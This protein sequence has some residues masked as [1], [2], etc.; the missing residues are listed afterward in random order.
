MPP[1]RSN[2][3][4]SLPTLGDNL[5]RVS[6]NSKSN[7]VLVLP[8]QYE[9]QWSNPIMTAL[10]PPPS[11]KPAQPQRKNSHH[12][13]RSDSGLALHTNQAAFRQRKNSNSAGPVST[14]H[15]PARALS[16]DSN[17]SVEEFAL[18]RSFSPELGGFVSNGRVIPDFFEP[19]VVKLAFSNKE[20]VRRLCAFAETRHDGSD[21]DFLRKVIAPH[22]PNVTT[23]DMLIRLQVE[24]Y[25]RA[26]G[27]LISSMSYISSNFTGTTATSPLELSSEVAGALKS[28]IKFCAR[29]ALPALDKVY[30]DAKSTAEDRLSKS[31]YPEFVKYQLSQ[32]LTTSLTSN[33]SLAGETNTPY[34]GLGEAFCLTDPHQPDNPVI[35]ASDGLSAML[36]YSRRQ[37]VGRNCRLLQ[38]IATEATAAFRLSQAVG[39]GREATELLINYRPDGTPYWNL[40]F[41]CPLMENGTVRYFL[42]AQVNVSENMGSD[43]M[44]IMGVLNFGPPR[45]EQ[46]TLS[47]ESPTSPIWPARQSSDKL[48][49]P[50]SNDQHEEKFEGK[51]GSR[52]WR[53]FHRLHRKA[54][55]LRASSPSHRSTASEPTTDDNS[56][57]P[58]ASRNCPPLSP[59]SAHMELHQR[60]PSEQQL[61]ENST[62]YSRFLVMRYTSP[63]PPSTSHNRRQQSGSKRLAREERS[64]SATPRLPVSFCSSHALS[65]LGLET[66]PQPHSRPPESPLLGSDIFSV[67][68]SHLNSPTLDRVFKA[69]MLARL[70][71][72]ESVRADLMVRVGGPE[73]SARGSRS[74]APIIQINGTTSGSATS[75]G[76]A[77]PFDSRPRVSSSLDRGSGLLSHVL[78]P[79]GRGAYEADC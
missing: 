26:L 78:S 57:P 3:A 38:G 56:S 70:D 23:P 4:D 39:A 51:P 12:R 67:L 62:P 36:G 79:G 60:R 59:F 72:G 29:S 46:P 40:L 25:S 18:G 47:P 65:L 71:R 69:E 34:P 17:S 7:P 41:I 77:L 43:Y 2:T 9:R 35:F 1:V 24:E 48:E 13:L 10:S 20:T 45:Q 75:S 30:R 61:D 74:G 21:I 76:E 32:R 49:V 5:N 63:H 15:L 68:S 58:Q 6:R 28:D 31:L 64:R 53:F 27:N 8:Q 44:E 11:S 55:S 19:A 50:N 52:R 73:G 54:P 42:G 16:F 66:Q 14:R 37:L 22:T 33:R